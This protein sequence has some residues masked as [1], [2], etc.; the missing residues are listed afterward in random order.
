MPSRLR[1]RHRRICDC[2]IGRS[3]REVK[4]PKRLAVEKLW[5]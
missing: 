2:L 4:R 5:L 3:S 1:A